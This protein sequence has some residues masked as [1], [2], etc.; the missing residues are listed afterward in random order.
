MH[1]IKNFFN[2]K[3]Q[4]VKNYI[5]QGGS[6]KGLAYLG[7][8]DTLESKDIKLKNIEKIGGTSVGAITA[9]LLS[10]GFNCESL[11]DILLDMDFENFLDVENKIAENPFYKMALNRFDRNKCFKEVDDIYKIIGHYRKLSK[12]ID[13]PWSFGFFFLEAYFDKNVKTTIHQLYKMYS[14][15]Y[16]KKGLAKGEK[17]RL[18]IEDQIYS[19]TGKNN[20]TF[21]ELKELQAKNKEKYK[22]LYLIGTNI[23][24]QQSEVFS[25]DNTP[26]LIISDAV[27][28]SMSLPVVFQPHQQYEKKGNKRCLASKKDLYIDGGVM[29]NY[30]IWL[31]DDP[32][33]NNTKD[34]VNSETLGFRLMPLNKIIQYSQKDIFTGYFQRRNESEIQNMED[35]FPFYILSMIN[36]FYNKQES[37]FELEKDYHVKRTIMIDDYKVSTF[38]FSLNNEEKQ[39]LIIAGKTSANKYIN[40]Y[41]PTRLDNFAELAKIGVASII[42][43]IGGMITYCC[44]R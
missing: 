24:T 12:E 32:K 23:R 27:R 22:L 5:F 8:L 42:F 41:K 35:N 6:V 19:Q 30:P 34:R 38:K 39:N 3:E 36:C 33:Q 20:L 25:Y 17:L 43:G 44:F 16:E 37:D 4:K 40:E 28:I 9:A 31:F 2:S 10:V 14:Y 11:R 1:V 29:D 7:A 15:L 18:W 21:K 13:G 26:N